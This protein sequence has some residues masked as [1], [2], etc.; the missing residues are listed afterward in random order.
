[1][2]HIS[3][4]DLSHRINFPDPSIRTHFKAATEMTFGQ[5]GNQSPDWK[6]NPSIIDTFKSMRHHLI[7]REQCFKGQEME[8]T[9]TKVL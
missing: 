7:G 3:R 2:K 8:E 4:V 1:M 6:V 9:A 5:R